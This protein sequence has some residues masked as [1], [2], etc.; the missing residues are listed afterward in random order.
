MFDYFQTF[1]KEGMSLHLGCSAMEESEKCQKEFVT[2]KEKTKKQQSF[3]TRIVGG[4]PAKKPMPW[5][6]L[7]YVKG[8]QCGGTLIN[9]EFVLTAAHC[10]C[11]G[12][13]L[14]ER[15]I[16]EVEKNVPNKIRVRNNQGSFL[17]F[18]L[19]C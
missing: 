4:H 1:S 14:C 3:G 10:F 13:M 17:H 8:S 15:M 12:A 19:L 18:I 5:M 16:M 11:G 7:I 2:K 6:A 9:N